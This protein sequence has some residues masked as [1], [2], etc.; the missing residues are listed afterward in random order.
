MDLRTQN[1]EFILEF[2]QCFK[3][4]S[5]LWKYTSTDYKN[6]NVKSVT[7]NKLLEINRKYDPNCN[8]AE[9]K[10]KIQSLRASYRKEKNKVQKSVK[11]GSG[12][13]EVYTPKLW[14]YKELD[15]LS[16]QVESKYQLKLNIKIEAFP[17]RMAHIQNFCLE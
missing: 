15:F 13:D 10:K 16:D 8:V 11:T 9:V 1:K 6:K 3:E 12:A 17:R 4:N 7:Y 14:Y 2:I 5:C